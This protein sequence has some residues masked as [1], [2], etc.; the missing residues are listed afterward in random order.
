M[1]LPIARLR[2]SDLGVGTPRTSPTERLPSFGRA[3]PL[4]PSVQA[5]RPPAPALAKELTLLAKEALVPLQ[6]HP[7]QKAHFQKLNAAFAWQ[8]ARIEALFSAMY[9]Q[10]VTDQDSHKIK[11][12]MQELEALEGQLCSLPKKEQQMAQAKLNKMC[13]HLQ[14]MQEF[15]AHIQRLD[16]TIEAFEERLKS[17]T[18]TFVSPQFSG[19]ALVNFAPLDKAIG[20]LLRYQKK[21]E[22]LPSGAAKTRENWTFESQRQFFSL[23][24]LN[25]QEAIQAAIEHEESYLA[26]AWS[27]SPGDEALTRQLYA[28]RDQENRL[29]AELEKQKKRV[30]QDPQL[31]VIADQ[32]KEAIQIVT[33]RQAV[34]NRKK[35]IAMQ[36]PQP[37]VP[38]RFGSEEW[39]ALVKQRPLEQPG[40]LSRTLS[41]LDPANWSDRTKD[42]V[43]RALALSQL[44]AQGIQFGQLLVRE[45]KRLEQAAKQMQETV[46]KAVPPEQAEKID[47]E[48]S[49]LGTI[50][51]DKF[52]ALHNPQAIDALC[53]KRSPEFRQALLK[54]KAQYGTKAPSREAV[55][56]ITD[57]YRLQQLVK[58]SPIANPFKHLSFTEWREVFSTP[59]EDSVT[60]QGMQF[61]EQF[62]QDF[63]QFDQAA[64]QTLEKVLKAVSPEHAEKIDKE[65][66]HLG[67]MIF[68]NFGQQSPETLK[69][70]AQKH[71]PEFLQALLMAK[72][73]YSAKGALSLQE[74][75]EIT[76]AYR[77]QQLVKAS[78]IA[79]PFKRLS[80]AQ[81]WEILTKSE[82]EIPSS[83]TLTKLAITSGKEDAFTTKMMQLAS[84]SATPQ[85]V[86]V[87]QQRAAG[88]EQ[89]Q[90]S[91]A[92]AATLAQKTHEHPSLEPLRKEVALLQRELLKSIEEAPSATCPLPELASWLQKVDDTCYGIQQMEQHIDK[93][94]QQARSHI[95]VDEEAVKCGQK[96]LNL[97]KQ[98][99]LVDVL[100]LPG[101]TVPVPRGIPTDRVEAFLR[102]Q[103]PELFDKW[104]KL[105]VLHA[106]YKGTTPFLAQPEAKK[107]LEGI[108]QAIYKAFK[109]GAFE[110]LAP[111][112]FLD[113]VKE[114]QAKGD[115]LMVRSTGA[116]D[117][118]QTA[119]AGGNVSRAY[120]SPAPEAL[121]EAFGDVVRSYFSYGSL[122]NRL[123][124]GLNPFTQELKMAVTAQQLIGEPVGG[125][126]F[127]QDIPVSLVLFTS[128]PLYV[129]GEKFRVMRVSATYGHG[130]A[131]VA[132]MGVTSDT[133]L[134]L[135]SEAHPDK[136]YVLYDNK[137]KP[138]RLAPVQTPEGIKLG[139][140]ANP[141]ELRRRPALS[142][143]MLRRLYVWGVVGEQF[144]D[145]KATDMEIVVKGKTIYPVQA[146]PV[147]RP[148]LLPTY[149][150]LKKIQALPQNPITE[151]IQAD[152]LVPGKASVVVAHNSEEIHCAATLAEA[153]KSYVPGKHKLVIVTRPEPPNSHPV[154][155]FSGLGVPCLI[156][157]REK[158]RQLLQKVDQDHPVAIDMQAATVNLWDGSL[159]NVQDAV[160][161]GFSVHPAKVAISLPLAAKLAISPAAVPQEVKDLV[162]A[163]RSATAQEVA[164]AKLKELREH[165]L[166]LSIKA[167]R[168]EVKAQIRQLISVPTDLREGYRILKELDKKVASA[169]SE[170][171]SSWHKNNEQ[172][173][174]RLFHANV[175]ETLLTGTLQGATSVG[176][177]SALDVVPIASQ[178]KNLIAYQ[179][180]FSHPIHFGDLLNLSS[181]AIAPQSEKDW[182][183]FLKELETLIEQG[184]IPQEQVSQFKKMMNVLQQTH[185]LATW[186]ALFFPMTNVTSSLKPLTRF[187]E[188]LSTLPTKETPALENLL[189]VTADLRSGKE[190]LD[191]F[192]DPVHLEEGMRWL[193]SQA[194]KLQTSIPIREEDLG[195]FQK[196]QQKIWP[197]S[198]LHIHLLTASPL[199]RMV[200]LKTMHELVE[201]YDLAIKTMKASS[202]YAPGEKVQILGRMLESYFNLLK[203]WIPLIDAKS[204]GMHPDWPIDKYMHELR[205]AFSFNMLKLQ[206]GYSTQTLLNP[207]YG[208]SALAAVMG[209]AADFTRNKPQSLE[210]IFTVIHQNLLILLSNVENTLYNAATFQQGHLPELFKVMLARFD[211]KGFGRS[212]QRLSAEVTDKEIVA[213]YNIPLRVHSTQLLLQYDKISQKTTLKVLFFGETEHSRWESIAHLVHLLDKTSLLKTS[214]SVQNQYNELNFSWE[215]QD[216]KNVSL[217][218]EL[219]NLMCDLSDY[220]GVEGALSSSARGRKQSDSIIREVFSSLSMEDDFFQLLTHQGFVKLVLD[221]KNEALAATLV[222]AVKNGTA[223]ADPQI[224]E[225]AYYNLEKKLLPVGL[226][227]E[228]A[229]QLLR[230]GLTGTDTQHYK[231][232][233]SLWRVFA[234]TYNSSRL[235]KS[236]RLKILVEST[237][238]RGLA[239][240]DANARLRSLYLLEQLLENGLDVYRDTEEAAKTGFRGQNQDIRLKSLDII[241]LLVANQTGYQ[242][243]KAMAMEGINDSKPAIRLK[244]ID[245]LI[246]AVHQGV[247]SI[248]QSAL[249][250]AQKG[251]VDPDLSIRKEA[252]TL[253]KALVERKVGL[254]TAQE[255]AARGMH[256]RDTAIQTVTLD[257]L[258]SLVAQNSSV[259]LAV[260]AVKQYSQNAN[261]AIRSLTI[262]LATAVVQKGKG[263]AVGL[264]VFT[265]GVAED[266]AGDLFP[267]YSELSQALLKTGKGEA[268]AETITKIARVGGSS[269]QLN[270]LR[271]LSS[272]VDAGQGLEVSAQTA[273]QNFWEKDSETREKASFLLRKLIEKN[274]FAPALDVCEKGIKSDDKSVQ[275]NALFLLT[276][277]IGHKQGYEV[278]K[279]ALSTRR[280]FSSYELYLLLLQSLVANG[281][282]YQI[283]IDVAWQMQ[284]ENPDYEYP[285]RQLILQIVA[286]GA[287]LDEAFHLMKDIP[288]DSEFSRDL[289]KLLREKGYA[290]AFKYRAP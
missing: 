102:K 86:L 21:V 178:M 126:Q 252:F 189:T 79:N 180:S 9:T 265:K 191:R 106:A 58:A 158:T 17:L 69:R 153:E 100:K 75:K 155:N 203:D 36:L 78:P 127:P 90:E 47:K 239:H 73:Q 130:E 289:L 264:E 64:K 80:F 32:L 212:I 123:N 261:P 195:I 113:W 150:D 27:K 28:L 156:A 271:L 250:V 15:G 216:P 274:S 221:K 60:A 240:S 270:A 104:Q 57:A 109:T 138:E 198:P 232:C 206:M 101:V 276:I 251:L 157:D 237:L 74:Q 88:A 139:K 266:I 19:E 66:S 134:L 56:A 161:R 1:T 228:L 287:S 260:D 258:L 37:V 285:C 171:Q 211:N 13:E 249:E 209:S 10:G 199:S 147:N 262:K 81:W 140:V 68:E 50:L 243:A 144:F 77:M 67:K 12:A 137:E 117:S 168:K 38:L 227:L 30:E 259:E 105:G 280:S 255:A 98:A 253:T 256:D 222:E 188:I 218:I 119:N 124:A 236:S 217:A 133:V 162:I 267:L 278:A 241:K 187:K 33:K 248:Y 5:P 175:L 170:A 223:S 61:G 118:R 120:V 149:L 190:H 46:L 174:R 244:S 286:K 93:L 54:A 235:E 143:E 20:S 194:Q 35:F 234:D 59:E 96:H 182:M 49:H 6:L 44:T 272:I 63:K 202:A 65:V 165:P 201:T 91:I 254:E 39:Q 14:E 185:M 164:L 142:E 205:N 160:V 172:Q 72:E 225:K 2:P 159:G 145:D 114:V 268:L 283:A 204:I 62:V 122:Q 22:G 179:K 281:E 238:K 242:T 121:A 169:F 111:P 31:K 245:L 7:S 213:R 26:N 24:L 229:E 92:V 193:Q 87:V 186:F 148:D 129:G 132:N 207:S 95:V 18:D 85:E 51:S 152:M 25:W 42:I 181:E 277:L 115:Y 176:Q 184:Q 288:A 226:G 257:L 45:P 210:D 214:A 4:P 16:L 284:K 263:E 233:A 141:P 183:A 135:I 290:P 11:E 23:N 154:V 108:N 167:Q 83:Q 55:Q 173:L 230:H 71:P 196:L 269:I 34:L 41:V 84:Q 110:D 219:V 275:N 107:L 279:E 131:V 40:L 192:A 166:V 82:D 52:S 76:D 70:W 48:A 247:A 146:R 231:D 200:A 116:E 103:T 128:E 197:K 136:L 282:G 177:Y 208:F 29:V 246:D 3:L 125:A 273:A 112:E 215:I 89:L 163:I 99:Q 43:Y 8:A 94:M 151:K 224:R 220:G 97:I 53:K